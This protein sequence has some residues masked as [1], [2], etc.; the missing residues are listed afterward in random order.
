MAASNHPPQD[1]SEQNMSD[2][3]AEALRKLTEKN[4]IASFAM[5]KLGMDEAARRSFHCGVR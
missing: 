2:E 5:Q 3:K 1:Q 4:K